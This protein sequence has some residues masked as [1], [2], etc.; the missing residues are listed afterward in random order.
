[1][2][3]IAVKSNEYRGGVCHPRPLATPY[4]STEIACVSF[5]D[6]SNKPGVGPRWRLS[7]NSLRLRKTAP[8]RSTFDFAPEE[9]DRLISFHA[10]GRRV[11][12]I[13]PGVTSDSS[14]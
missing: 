10:R 3:A 14:G 4:V 1:V 12:R 2:A 13:F 11:V 8:Q 5:G 6:Q 9:G 7:L